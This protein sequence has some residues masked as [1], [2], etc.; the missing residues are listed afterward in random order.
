[1]DIDMSCLVYCTGY[2]SP[3]RSSFKRISGSERH[4]RMQEKA[5]EIEEIERLQLEL[6]VQEAR[7]S[8]VKPN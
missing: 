8:H 7:M 5:M 6:Q 2:M 3:I 1:M 4:L